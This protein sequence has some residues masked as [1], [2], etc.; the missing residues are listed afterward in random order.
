[1]TVLPPEPFTSKIRGSAATR[2]VT[3]TAAPSWASSATPMWWTTRSRIPALMRTVNPTA[4]DT[5]TNHALRFTAIMPA[6]RHPIPALRI[7]Q[8]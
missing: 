5:T 1:M 3:V 6:A 2:P 8:R 4:A 7:I